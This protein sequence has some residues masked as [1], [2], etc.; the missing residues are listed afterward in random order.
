MAATYQEGSIVVKAQGQS[1]ALRPWTNILGWVMGV[2][3]LLS[4]AAI[5][6]YAPTERVQGDV[7][8]IFYYHV[9]LAWISYLAFFVVFV[10]SV[11]Y[12]WRRSQSWDRLALASG[13]VGVLFT[14]LFTVTGSIWAKPIWGT[15]WTWDARLTSTLI[16]WFIYVG[17]IMVRAYVSGREQGARLAAVVGIIGFIDIPIVQLSVTWWRTLHPGP[18]IVRE[19]G[20]IGLPAEMLITLGISLLAV[21]LL[22]VYLLLQRVRLEAMKDTVSALSLELAEET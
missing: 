2:A 10:S 8:R 22:Y 17:Y 3:V 11:M 18:T 14:T 6:L 9:S 1:S 13:E 20:D 16:L 12:L 7:Q 4:I 21:T 15:W 19:T 5:F